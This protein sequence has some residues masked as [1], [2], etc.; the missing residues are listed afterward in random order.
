MAAAAGVPLELVARIGGHKRTSMTL[1]QY[2]HVLVDEP[3]WRL[4]ELRRDVS[5][6]FGMESLAPSE[7]ETPAT[8]GGETVTDDLMGSTGIEPVTPRV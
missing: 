1:D 8:K 3:R 2:S 4:D 7:G 6:M 5:V